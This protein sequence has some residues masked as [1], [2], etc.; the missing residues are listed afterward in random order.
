MRKLLKKLNDLQAE[1]KRLKAKSMSLPP[2]MQQITR[3]LKRE[4]A[5]LSKC[6][7]AVLDSEDESEDSDSDDE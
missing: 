2:R 4:I 6:D 7:P 1:K 3:Q 5:R